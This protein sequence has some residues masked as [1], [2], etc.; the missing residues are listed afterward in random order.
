M[1]KRAAKSENLT[2]LQKRLKIQALCQQLLKRQDVISSGKLQLLG[3]G[4]VKRRAGRDWPGL[5][6]IVHETVDTVFR[7]HLTAADLSLK[8]QDDS[9]LVLF[10]QE[11]GEAA[12]EKAAR[13]AAEIGE[14]LY[15]A[16]EARFGTVK[17]IPSAAALTAA[18][19][20]PG[21]GFWN[22]GDAEFDAPD[23]TVTEVP[24][25]QGIIAA[26]EDLGLSFAYQPIWEVPKNAVTSFLCWPLMAGTGAT[27][28][29]YLRAFS[30]KSYHATLEHDLKVLEQMRRDLLRLEREDKQVMLVCPLHYGSVVRDE[31]FQHLI[32][33][34]AAIPD[35][36]RKYL[37]LFIIDPPQKF[38]GRDP[39][40]FAQNLRRKLCRAIYVNVPPPYDLS[41]P[42]FKTSGI[43]GLSF[44]VG[45][46]MEEEK[47]MPALD[48]FCLESKALG[49]RAAILDVPSRSLVSLAISYEAHYLAGDVIAA[50]VDAPDQIY[51]FKHDML[52]LKP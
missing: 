51:R 40:W 39:L 29:A 3:L 50:P 48:R 31:G 15:A 18:D 42:A 5:Q 11:T 14:R 9:Y 41:H 47:I 25:G 23:P 13:I 35:D 22:M 52:Y 45:E 20:A 12:A 17:I 49:A 33:R 16:N 6:K 44:I 7:R 10:A 21:S 37:V 43:D 38:I 32:H 24:L 1:D 8:Y 19:V 26:E 2:P 4:K 36:L 34:C 27:F 30:G 46:G 28:A